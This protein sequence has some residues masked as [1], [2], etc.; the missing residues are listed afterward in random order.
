MSLT[1]ATK[2]IELFI[3]YAHRDQR[4]RD[5]LETH[6]SS[7]KRDGFISTW[8]DRKIAAGEE[9]AGVINEHLNTAH[10]ILLL[11]SSDFT[12]S[13]YCNDVE[14][15][16]ALERHTAGEAYVIPI[17][18]RRVDWRNAPF[19]KLQALPEN[20]K[21]VTS[22]KNR[23]DAFFNIAQGIRRVVEEQITKPPATY[24][25]ASTQRTIVDFPPLTN[26]KIIQQREEAVKDIYARLSQP[27]ITALVLTGIGGLGKST[28][29][30]LLYHYAEE[31]RLRGNGLFTS[32]TLW[33]T[34][35]S[36]VTLVDL[37]VSFF[38]ALDK[39]FPDFSN[40]APSHQALALF[41]AL[42]TL[43]KPRII[44]LDQ[45]ENLLDW[46]T[47]RA[48]PN[49]P[50]IGELLDLLNSQPSS[51]RLLLTSRPWPQGTHEFPPIYMQEYAV[52][53]LST[54]EGLTLLRKQGI[55][56]TQGTDGEL[57]QAVVLCEGHALSLT[58][59]A[60]LLRRN[61]SLSLSL[62]FKDSLYTSL[63]S[64]D[65]ARGLLDYIY[66]H[67][68]SEPQRKLLQVFSIYREPV[69]LE[70]AQALIAEIP[71]AHILL[72][73]N[74][75]LTQHLLN[76]VGEGEG[77]YQLHAIVGGY[78]Q[79]HFVES[80]EQA[81]LQALQT[82]HGKAAQYYL[83][84][85][86][87]LCPPLGKRRGI[88]DV[89][90]LIEAVWHLCQAEQWQGAYELMEQEEIFTDL[91]RWGNDT[92]LLELYQMLLLLDQW[93]PE[94]LQA[95]NIYRYMGE[96]CRSLGQLES[97]LRYSEMALSLYKDLK[98]RRGEGM[99][100]NSLGRIYNAM[101]QKDL[102]REC[103]VQA[104]SIYKEIEDH[105]DEETVL[106]NLGRVYSD[107]GM[108][109]QAQGC[110]E[111]ALSKSREVGNC[112][113]EGR[114][115]RG[116]GM[117]YVALRMDREAQKCYEEALGILRNV[118]DRAEEGKVLNNLGL[119]Y[120][121]SGKI[122]E[123]LK[124]LKQALHIHREVG[125]RDWEGRILNN[126]GVFYF[127]MNNYELALSC[128]LLAKEIYREV[129]VPRHSLAQKWI[130]ALS[131]KVGEKSFDVLLAQIEPQASQIVEKAL[132]E[133]L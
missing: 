88:S 77:R 51:C 85:A 42:K 105:R 114:A 100:L 76:A 50:G 95:A 107:L 53:G 124:F 93:Y 73:L 103:Y 26:P 27:S 128:L 17:I 99:V 111:E 32:E 92:V 75:L 6:L 48:L 104:L 133:G 86:A 87:K 60:S 64:G 40:L 31:Q 15:K 94:H 46:Q 29:A 79:N 36:A 52:Q 67:Q 25:I 80:N 55:E 120:G 63:W 1:S 83:Q 65:I 82:T 68:L 116:L 4:L 20:A 90:P 34:L 96:I 129:Q 109:R 91:H 130:D 126:L 43:E 81:N 21:P 115:L 56:L 57:R 108:L 132:K 127:K 123:A 70:A 62:L 69:P 71:K 23:D 61:R 30:A 74:V 5:Q 13:E 121:A 131:K 18:L 84:K 33:L 106:N 37:A 66:T 118:R 14:V 12:A 101:E 112:N 2:P 89:H 54:A 10:I 110:Y 28:L 59:L 22:W 3:S 125:S 113:E 35:G 58:L 7:L 102:A 39:P 119:L 8:H 41:N 78:V 44:I 122:E 97:G 16:R 47:G 49:R 45:F 117:V 19:G 9:W 98:D 11:V 72:A 38:A 24:N